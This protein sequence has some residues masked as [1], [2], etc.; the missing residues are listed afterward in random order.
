[1]NADRLTLHTVLNPDMMGWAGRGNAPKPNTLHIALFNWERS[2]WVA[3]SQAADS[4]TNA[5][6]QYGMRPNPT[7][8]EINLTWIRPEEFLHPL[9]GSVLVAAWTDAAV[10]GPPATPP[11]M[12]ADVPAW[13]FGPDRPRDRPPGTDSHRLTAIE[14][15]LSTGEERSTP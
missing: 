9:T 3:Q 6:Q 13:L 12:P 1:M 11:S 15:T 8:I 5:Y 14:L 10:A 2:Q 7:P 4:M